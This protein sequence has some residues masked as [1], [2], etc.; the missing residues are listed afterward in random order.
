MDIYNLLSLIKKFLHSF[1]IDILLEFH[2]LLSPGVDVDSLRWRFDQR[3]SD[4]KIATKKLGMF[5]WMLIVC[6]WRSI[7]LSFKIF[8]EWFP[9]HLKIGSLLF[10]T[11][12][13]SEIRIA[14]K[15]RCFKPF[16]VI[17]YFPIFKCMNERY[18]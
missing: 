17:L 8:Y 11:T 12:T 1:N 7:S 6:Y 13:P 3:S 18:L 9:A 2:R 16:E 14:N 15:F 4:K 5:L 10:Y